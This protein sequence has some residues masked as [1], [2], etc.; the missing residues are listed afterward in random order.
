MRVS[1]DCVGDCVGRLSG[2]TMQVLR[3][4]D[5]LDIVEFDLAPSVVRSV[6][7]CTAGCAQQYYLCSRICVY[8]YSTQSKILIANERI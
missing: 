1:Y 7:V 5:V 2:M 4:H 8:M 6:P 3:C